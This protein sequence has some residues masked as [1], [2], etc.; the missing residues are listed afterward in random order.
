MPCIAWLWIGLRESRAAAS[1]GMKSCRTQRDFHSSI[2]PPHLRSERA[3]LRPER[4]IWSLKGLIWGQ[5]D[6]L[7]PITPFQRAK[8]GT[9][10]AS[11]W[12]SKRRE[13]QTDMRMYPF[14][15]YQSQIRNVEYRRDPNK[16]WAGTSS[17]PYSSHGS[18]KFLINCGGLHLKWIQLAPLWRF[19]NFH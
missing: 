4:Q 7:Y 3:D 1:K 2:Y 5:D 15:K 16:K 13:G 8:W 14:M 12:F 9:P 18:N 10:C 17:P 11:A 6:L 19:L